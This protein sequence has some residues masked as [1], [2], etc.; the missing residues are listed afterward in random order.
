MEVSFELVQDRFQLRTFDISSVE[1]LAF[2]TAV[3]VS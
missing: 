3:L 2:A 1:Q